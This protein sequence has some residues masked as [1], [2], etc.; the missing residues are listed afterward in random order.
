M[1]KLEAHLNPNL[2][3]DTL[4]A[5]DKALSIYT[6]IQPETP[7][8]KMFYQAGINHALRWLRTRATVKRGT[9]QGYDATS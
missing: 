1:S 2:L 4:D 8:D 7:R 5:A 3:A 6:D 9:A